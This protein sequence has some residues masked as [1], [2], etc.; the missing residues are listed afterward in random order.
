[1]ESRQLHGA[2]D[3]F[4]SG[5]AFSKRPYKKVLMFQVDGGITNIIIIEGN[6]LMMT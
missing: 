5:R 1:M 2:L 3:I 4:E 6:S